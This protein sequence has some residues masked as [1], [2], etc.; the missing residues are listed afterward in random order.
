MIILITL[1]LNYILESQNQLN[2]QNTKETRSDRRRNY[3]WAISII[4]SIFLHSVARVY[5]KHCSW[6]GYVPY[7]KDSTLP[8]K[9]QLLSYIVL[10]GKL[11]FTYNSQTSMKNDL[12]PS[13]FFPSCNNTNFIS[14]RINQYAHIIKTIKP[15]FRTSRRNKRR[16]RPFIKLIYRLEIPIKSSTFKRCYSAIQQCT[17]IVFSLR[18]TS[19]I[20]S[21]L[22]LAI[23]WM[24]CLS[25]PPPI[26]TEPP[27]VCWGALE[28]PDNAVSV[29]AKAD[30][31]HVGRLAARGDVTV[32]TGFVEWWVR[33]YN[34]VSE[35]DS[36]K[37][38]CDMSSTGH[39]QGRS[40]V[41]WW[42]QRRE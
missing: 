7:G 3:M 42:S 10:E 36:R 14:G 26:R 24:T 9:A 37:R 29:P 27:V 22:A 32:I 1:G 35:G 13:S 39:H 18:I 16:H 31:D 20:T 23:I 12:I 17:H 15:I 19:S 2:C 40:E 21:R 33:L 4:L 5:Q 25:C 6:S 38:W 8:T 34:G 41:G 28:A 11:T 30:V